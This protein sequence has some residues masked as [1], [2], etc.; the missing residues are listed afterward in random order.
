M[1]GEQRPRRR[2]HRRRRAHRRHGLGGA[3]QHRRRQ[4][5]PAGHRRQRQRALVRARPSAASPN[6]LATLR[7]TDGYERFLAWGKDVLQRTPVVGKPL[8]ETLHGAKKGLKDFIRAAGHVR[9]P[10]AEVRRPDRRP[11]HRGRGVRAAPGQALPR[12]GASCTASPRR[13]AAT[14][15]RSQHEEDRFHTVGVMDPLT[16]EP[17]RAVRR[18]VLDLGVRRRDGQDR[19][20]ARGRRRDHGGDAAPGGPRRS[21][22]S[23]SRTGCSTSASPSSTPRSPRPGSR[24]AGC[25]R[26]SPSTRPSSTGPSTRS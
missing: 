16:C 6:H 21:S 25:T 12:P 2:G 13:A 17:A 23:G 8:Y 22:P 20:G 9:G 1:Q 5:P 4:G 14:S 10:R 18:P 3:E 7:T 15:P 24:P 11:R 26:S 19:R